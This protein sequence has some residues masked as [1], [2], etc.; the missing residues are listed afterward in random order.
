MNRFVG[1]DGGDEAGESFG[2]FLFKSSVIHKCFT[3]QTLVGFFPSM[4]SL[5]FHVFDFQGYELL[6]MLTYIDHIA[7]IWLYTFVW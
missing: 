5:V 4:S 1:R 3:K 2:E 7:W 6:H